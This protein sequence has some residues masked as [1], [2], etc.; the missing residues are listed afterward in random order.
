ML[1]DIEAIRSFSNY[2]HQMNA[3]KN[4]T[5]VNKTHNGYTKLHK[6]IFLT[7]AATFLYNHKENA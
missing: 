7:P 3:S 5:Y 1:I 2:K 6:Q 4:C